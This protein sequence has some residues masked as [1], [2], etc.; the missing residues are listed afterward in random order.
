[1]NAYLSPLKAFNVIQYVTFRTAYASLTAL[2]IGLLLG[3]W[4]IKRLQEFQIVQHIREEGPKSHQAK[5]G[6]PT[7]GG[8]LIVVSVILP[9]LLWANLRNPFVWLVILSTLACGGIGFADDYL[10]IRHKRNLGLTPRE[11]L[12]FQFLVGLSIAFSLLILANHHAYSTTLTVPFV[13]SLQPDLVI[14]SLLPGRAF[15]LAYVPFLVFVSLLIVFSS[16]AVN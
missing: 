9:T 3:P 7:M 10:K 15:I 2:L 13:K 14:D 4:L 12:T 8:I 1:M 16:N 11:K 6:T 5:A